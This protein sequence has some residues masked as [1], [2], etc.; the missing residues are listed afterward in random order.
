MPYRLTG[1]LELRVE[2]AQEALAALAKGEAF[3][4]K[5]ATAMNERSSRAHTVFV[6]HV[7]QTRGDAMVSSTLHM[8]DL[9]GSERIKKSKAVGARRREAVGINES[10]LVLGKVISA[11]VEG[12]SHV[13]YLECKLTTLL[14]GALG[15]ASRT[16][17][18]VCCRQD[19]N[20]AEETLQALR[21][22]ERCALVSNVKQTVA[23][24]S[25]SEA[26]RS[27]DATLTQCENSLENL[28]R[29]KKQD[30][31]AFKALQD[32]IQQLSQRRRAIA[33]VARFEERQKAKKME[34]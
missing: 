20:Q 8:V 18:V 1:A 5:A 17:A 26:L 2:T 9:A 32:R 11:L 28:R 4:H 14:K 24:S 15:G 16:T 7:R 13:P 22:G 34:T 33:D 3:K 10:L 19:D 6:L 31:P 25:A 27:I 23:A 30:L 21:F 12:K 29:R